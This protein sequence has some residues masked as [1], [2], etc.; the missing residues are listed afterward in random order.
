[1]LVAN[2]H[3]RSSLRILELDVWRLRWRH[4]ITCP[5]HQRFEG[6]PKTDRYGDTVV[7]AD[8]ESAKGLVLLPSQK[9]A[10]VIDTENIKEQID[11]PMAC[12][13]ESIRSLVREGRSRSGCPVTSIGKKEINGQTVV[14]FVVHGT[15]ADP[16]W[17][18]ATVDPNDREAGTCYLG[19]PRIVNMGPVGLAR[20]CTLRSWLSQWSF[21][22]SRA[23]GIKNAQNVT[24]P[25]LVI[26]NTADNACTPSHTHR[27]YEAVGHK[28][29]ELREIKGATH[30]YA[31]QPK[32]CAEAIDVCSE[33]LSRKGFSNVEHSA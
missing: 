21:D 13:F 10:V 27:L 17:L 6:D 5:S 9:V 4:A 14:G 18:D 20:F 16:R 26:G 28:N 12:I 7:I 30:Y 22:E 23:N 33:W 31:G 3:W 25:V 24:C 32:H 1:V 15:M 29:K 19:D 11:N 2:H 8:Y